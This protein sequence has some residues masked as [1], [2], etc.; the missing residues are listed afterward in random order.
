MGIRERFMGTR[1]YSVFLKM[2]IKQKF[3]FTSAILLIITFLFLIIFIVSDQRKRNY[4]ELNANAERLTSLI[5]LTNIENVWN[6]NQDGLTKNSDSFFQDTDIVSITISDKNESRLIDLKKD[7]QGNFDFSRSADIVRDDNVIGKVNVSFTSHYRDISIG[8]TR[9]KI[10]IILLIILIM[11]IAGMNYISGLIAAPLVELTS[12]V[13]QLASGE[14]VVPKNENMVV[15][16]FNNEQISKEK[17]ELGILIMNF[18]YLVLKFREIVSTTGDISSTLAA[19]SKELNVTAN[20]FSSNAQNQAAASEEINA[21]VEEISAG[22]ESIAAI[23]E[24]QANSFNSVTEQIKELAKGMGEIG[25]I[26]DD[27]VSKIMII[28]REA[29]ASEKSIKSMN[30]SMMN[31]AKSSGD[32]TNII[33]MITGIADRI[34]LLS[35]NAAIEAARAGDAGRG[36]A[37]VADEISKLADQTTQSIKEINHLIKANESEISSSLSGVE[38]AIQKISY[39]IEGVNSISGVMGEIQTY[40]KKKVDES[41]TVSEEV[42]ALR[43]NSEQ[44]RTATN[45][46]KT[47]IEEIVKSISSISESTQANAEGTADMAKSSDSILDMAEK[48]KEEISYFKIQN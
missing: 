26:I 25:N 28:N 29:N 18:R 14:L 48:L 6:F 9:N 40:M 34:N 2:N 19:S 7:I 39:I 8:Q 46:Q 35:L 5:A 30:D 41:V 36:F 13:R 27:T 32:M 47:G 37:V 16:N 33:D 17:N 4:A 45:E 3:T 23:A 31:I 22:S 1:L 24:T 10:S 15:D 11:V 21:T 44:I 38:N 12:R 43:E 42:D 20:T